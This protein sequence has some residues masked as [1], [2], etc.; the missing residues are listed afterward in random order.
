MVAPE[1]VRPARWNIRGVLF[2]NGVHSAV[3]GEYDHESGH[4]D[5]RVGTR[6]N[7]SDAHPAGH[8][9]DAGTPLWYVQPPFLTGAILIQLLH[10]VTGDEEYDYHKRE[11]HREEILTALDIFSAQEPADTERREMR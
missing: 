8:P 4:R 11:G 10:V 9:A 2:D 3:W 6:W 5:L 7:G 1:E